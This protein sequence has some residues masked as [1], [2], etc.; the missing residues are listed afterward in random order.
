MKIIRVLFLL[1][2]VFGLTSCSTGSGK[3]RLSQIE[4]RRQIASEV[5]S[6][7]VQSEKQ[8]L[9]AAADPADY[10]NKKMNVLVN[11][12]LVGTQLTEKFDARLAELVKQKQINPTADIHIL[13]TESQVYSQLLA[14]RL[15]RQ[16][17]EA[18]IVSLLSG[19][20]AE[21]YPNLGIIGAQGAVDAQLTSVQTELALG[22]FYSKLRT[23]VG[24]DRY[25]LYD[26][27]EK[28]VGTQKY[29]QELDQS[30]T[31]SVTQ[32]ET[33]APQNEAELG[34][35]KPELKVEIKK[36]ARQVNLQDGEIGEALRNDAP[37]IEQYLKEMKSARAP[38]AVGQ[39]IHPTVDATGNLTGAT[40]PAGAWAL[41]FDDGPHPSYTAKILK[42]LADNG[43]GATFFELAQVANQL[44][45]PVAAVVASGD[46]TLPHP[47][48]LANHSYSHPQIN[49]LGPVAMNHEIA[50]ANAALTDI[51][52][53]AL[54]AYHEQNKTS[55]TRQ[56]LKPKFF[57]LP[58]G[59]GVKDRRIRDLLQT[60]GLVHVFWNVDSL[61]WQD[62]N[63]Q[64]V[65]NR[66]ISQMKLEGHGVILFH[67]IHPQ[68]VQASDMVMKWIKTQP[69]LRTVTM[70]DIVNELNCPTAPT[71]P[72]PDV[73]RATNW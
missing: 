13:D 14:I 30:G 58:Y 60:V 19:L 69:N 8:K 66:T 25:A 45:T 21:K 40:F 7:D 29:F 9:G 2:L 27:R 52:N 36:R 46:L 17:Q 63:P 57:R 31:D 16:K 64:S 28:V 32:V 44:Q 18:M 67:D 59:A 33:L 61:D 11:A 38:Q 23:P 20:L 49:K 54:T 47:N 12:Y 34:T 39:N 73:W 65:Y 3:D 24:V 56:N 50:E 10:V 26:V 53:K 48:A 1:L 22:A 68:T 42:N 70:P 51:W 5:N 55:D 35:L 6:N 4:L 15:L 72:C 37:L 62:H 41:T 71:T 43:V